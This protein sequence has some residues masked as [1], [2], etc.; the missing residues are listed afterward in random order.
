[1]VWEPT[2]ATLQTRSPPAY[3]DVTYHNGQ[4]HAALPPE[5]PMPLPVYPRAEGYG[6]GRGRGPMPSGLP[7]DTDDEPAAATGPR[8]TTTAPPKQH[9]REGHRPPGA[10]GMTSALLNTQSGPHR[11]DRTNPST[12]KPCNT[13]FSRPYDL[14]RHEETVHNARKQKVQC[15]VCKKTF[16]RADRL[17]QHYRTCHPDSNFP[18]KAMHLQRL[19]RR[20][21]YDKH[22]RGKAFFCLY[23]HLL[24]GVT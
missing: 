24:Q 19:F 16:G 21:L 22:C 17:T 10:V 12:G 2:L 14:T 13:V 11:C 5:V 18:G 15:D 20:A 1:M 3:P 8:S 7:V 9:Q 4:P 6:Q 23:S